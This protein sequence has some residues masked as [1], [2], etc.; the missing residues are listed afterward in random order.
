M[1]R[2]L[3]LPLQVETGSQGAVEYGCQGDLRRR[4]EQA[5]VGHGCLSQEVVGA[6]PQRLWVLQRRE[7]CLR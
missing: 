6:L 3:T 1:L 4:E 5:R 2:L 7:P